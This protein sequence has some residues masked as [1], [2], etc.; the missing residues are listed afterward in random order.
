M[1]FFWQN[2]TMFMCREADS[3]QPLQHCTCALMASM[4]L[5]FCLPAFDV[6]LQCAMGKQATGKVA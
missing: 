1:Q 3:K 2:H 6:H 4:L 5:C